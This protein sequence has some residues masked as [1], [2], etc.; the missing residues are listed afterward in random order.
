MNYTTTVSQCQNSICDN[1]PRR[2][3]SYLTAN[4][5]PSNTWQRRSPIR[6][7]REMWNK[8]DTNEQLYQETR[9]NKRWLYIAALNSKETENKRSV[10]RQ[11]IFG[12]VWFDCMENWKYLFKTE[13]YLTWHSNNSQ[14]CWSCVFT[15]SKHRIFM[16]A[17]I[18][19]MTSLAVLVYK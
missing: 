15:I 14:K 10:T 7:W 6:N 11:S 17:R 1:K 19:Y 2:A 8:L 12:S 5:K 18:K 16:L 9:T 13:L 4:H 3:Y